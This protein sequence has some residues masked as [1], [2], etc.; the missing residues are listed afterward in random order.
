ML[1]FMGNTK[2]YRI[3]LEIENKLGFNKYRSVYSFAPPFARKKE[4]VQ[5]V[6]S[7]V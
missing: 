5:E 6:I 7:L 4:D 3:V 1:F 2:F